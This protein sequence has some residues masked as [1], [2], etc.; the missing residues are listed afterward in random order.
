MHSGSSWRATS[1]HLLE[2]RYFCTTFLR[3]TA[4]NKSHSKKQ[5]LKICIF[6][7]NN[8]CWRIRQ[9]ILLCAVKMFF[10]MIRVIHVF[11]EREGFRIK[12][13][14]LFC[15]TALLLCR[16]GFSLGLRFSFWLP[17]FTSRSIKSVLLKNNNFGIGSFLWFCSFLMGRAVSL[18]GGQI[19]KRLLIKRLS[20][21]ERWRP[22][23]IHRHCVGNL[24]PRWASRSDRARKFRPSPFRCS[25]SFMPERLR[26]QL[27]GWSIL[28]LCLQLLRVRLRCRRLRGWKSWSCWHVTVTGRWP[29]GFAVCTDR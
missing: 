16:D 15:P 4:S 25:T 8:I 9:E 20:M 18:S 17:F 27:V 1:E 26:R 19:K 13:R 11:A 7:E 23:V 2:V 5:N 21:C 29:R 12:S 3:S 28:R 10:S 14:F 6:F 24:L 22:F